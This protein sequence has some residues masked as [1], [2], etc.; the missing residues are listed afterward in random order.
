MNLKILRDVV[1]FLAI[2]SLA[3]DCNK[4]THEYTPDV[5]NTEF[6]VEPNT[7]PVN[8]TFTF[9]ASNSYCEDIGGDEY[10][11]TK[12][13]D[14]D[15]TGPEDLWWDTEPDNADIVTHIYTEAKTYRVLLSVRSLDFYMDTTSRLVVVT[16][17]TNT[18][19]GAVFSID[20]EERYPMEDFT[21]DASLSWDNEDA[22]EDLQVRWDWEDDGTYDTDFTTNKI[23]AHAYAQPGI[24]TIRLQIKD[25]GEL[26][27]E[28]TQIATVLEVLG[29][30]CPLVPTVTDIDGNQYNTV[31]IGDQCWMKENLKTTK[32]DDGTPIPN[33]EDGNEWYWLTTGAYVWYENV[34]SWKDKYGALYN[35][36]A[37]D[38]PNGLCPFGWHVP[39][40]DELIELTDYI[41]GA[42]QDGKKIKSCRQVNSPLGGAC[43]TSEHP[44]WN[45]STTGD[46]GTD[47]LG[48]SGLPGGH[49]PY[50]NNCA[51]EG[52]G[53]LGVWW[54]ST[55]TPTSEFSAYY[56]SLSPENSAIVYED[57]YKN[58]YSVRCIK[59]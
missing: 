43:N 23:A 4:G 6:A 28:T 41:G 12:Q 44:R 51:F 16:E 21:V 27:G 8:T 38:N 1:I 36:S 25:T 20:P 52:L 18:P 10:H 58:G 39:T 53:N 19:P 48:F 17:A 55:H 34:F 40:T 30:P 54:S 59:D 2:I 11:L 57:S 50:F 7:G 37:V 26:T 56:L 13:W 9:D 24:Y 42:T 31:L 3:S 14:F 22:T 49:R 33:V 5:F 32:Y 35:W 45:E 15:Y 47:I 46:Y 29:T